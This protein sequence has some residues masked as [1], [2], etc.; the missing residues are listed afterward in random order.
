M[1]SHSRRGHY[2]PHVLAADVDMTPANADR[3][4]S[5][6]HARNAIDDTNHA[7]DCLAQHRIACTLPIGA[8][9]V[10]GD[11]ATVDRSWRLVTHHEVPWTITGG[12]LARPAVHL[13][14][15]T[16]EEHAESAVWRVVIQSVR[17][18][19]RAISPKAI[20]VL[21]SDVMTEPGV[22]ISDW[23]PWTATEMAQARRVDDFMVTVGDVSFAALRFAVWVRPSEPPPPLTLFAVVSSLSVREVIE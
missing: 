12:V 3:P 21:D 7:L 1:S 4:L 10:P 22:A 18:P 2:S 6:I 20:R 8:L 19:I 17:S 16:V 5:V 23:S 11:V 9:S 13:V 15:A 14:G